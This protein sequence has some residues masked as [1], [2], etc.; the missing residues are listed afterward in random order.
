MSSTSPCT[1]L[2]CNEANTTIQILTSIFNL[3]KTLSKTIKPRYPSQDGITLSYLQ[4]TRLALNCGLNMDVS[5]LEFP[6]NSLLS[7]GALVCVT[8]KAAYPKACMINFLEK[9]FVETRDLSW[10]D[11]KCPF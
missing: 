10:D 6:T 9:H 2:P 11:N 1:K 7:I 5:A 4:L 3:L 8:S